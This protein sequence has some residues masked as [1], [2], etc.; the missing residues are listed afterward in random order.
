MA[1]ATQTRARPPVILEPIVPEEG[2][3]GERAHPCRIEDCPLPVHPDY[4]FCHACRARLGREITG[5]ANR[6]WW[7]YLAEPRSPYWLYEHEKAL[8]AANAVMRQH[9]AERRE[10]EREGVTA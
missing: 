7:L 1:M 9:R 4:V 10:R 5:W 2:D 3:P 8:A 6:T